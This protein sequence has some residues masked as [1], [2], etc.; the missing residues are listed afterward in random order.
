[1]AD[2]KV[3][4]EVGQFRFSGEGEQQWLAQQMDK[5]LRSAES[6]TRLA[7]PKARTEP[8]VGC[9]VNDAAPQMTGE[10]LPHFLTRTKATSQVDRYLAT[11][12]W[13]HRKEYEQVK[14]RD[15]T[16]ALKDARQNRLSNPADCLGK[17]TTKGH[18]VKDG[19]SFYVT[20]EG[21]KH[22]GL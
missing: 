14:T 2:A 6:L 21:R 1:M 8:N 5:I 18:C 7:P 11:A 12:E 13:L 16:K 3:E 4:V 22:L 17:N 19:K 15:V 10:A 20:P 9:E